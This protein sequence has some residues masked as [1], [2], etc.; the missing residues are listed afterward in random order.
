[1]LYFANIKVET[2]GIAQLFPLVIGRSLLQPQLILRHI[3]RVS[4]IVG[5]LEIRLQFK[6]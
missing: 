3:V 5:R 2:Y 1:M 4:G 6:K